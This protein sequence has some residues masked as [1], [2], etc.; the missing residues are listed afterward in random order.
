MI[1]LVQIG[2]NLVKDPELRDAR[3]GALCAEF[4]VA[5]KSVRYDRAAGSDVIDQVFI[6]VIA[7][8]DVAE[9]VAGLGQ[10]TVVVV[11]GR[12]SQQEIEGKDGRKERKTK[13]EAMTVQVVRTPPGDRLPTPPP[14]DD[15]YPG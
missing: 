15:R 3:N 1:N 7:W 12:L 2:G 6:R 4:T 8:E 5:C 14:G 9:V 11:N 13:V 10:G